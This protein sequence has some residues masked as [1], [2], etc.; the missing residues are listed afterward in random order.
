[1]GPLPDS[2]PERLDYREGAF[3]TFAFQRWTVRPPETPEAMMPWHV[4]GTILGLTQRLIR[5]VF[6]MERSLEFFGA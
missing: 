3:P 5:T 2:H 4:Q 1:M 6:T